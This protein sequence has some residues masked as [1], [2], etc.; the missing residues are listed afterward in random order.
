[1]WEFWFSAIHSDDKTNSLPGELKSWQNKIGEEQSVMDTISTKFT[2]TTDFFLAAEY[3]EKIVRKLNGIVFE[4]R[5]LSVRR[6]SGC[7]ELS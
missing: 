7:Q 4:L 5:W 2:V 1:M 6:L 3:E